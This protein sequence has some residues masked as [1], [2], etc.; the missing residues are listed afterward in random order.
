MDIT[1]SE[2]IINAIGIKK[3]IVFGI[4]EDELRWR[5][6]ETLSL[7]TLGEDKVLALKKLIEGVKDVYGSKAILFT[8]KTW[9]DAKKDMSSVIVHK[10]EH[11]DDLLFTFVRQ[12]PHKWLFQQHTKVANAMLAYYVEHIEYIPAQQ[13]RDYRR[14]AFVRVD[15]IYERYGKKRKED[16]VFYSSDVRGKRIRDILLK[17]NLVPETIDLLAVHKKEILRYSDLIPQIGKQFTVSGVATD[18]VPDKHTWGEHTFTFSD[19]RRKNRVVIDTFTD[20]ENSDDDDDREPYVSEYFW[21]NIRIPK[22]TD[23]EEDSAENEES[24]I[25]I[26]IPVQPFVIVFDLFRHLRLSVHVNYLN[27]YVYDDTLADKLILPQEVKYLISMLVEQKDGNF[28]DIVAGKGG[29]AIIL[30][31]G[32]PGVGKTLTAEVFAEADKKPLYSVQASQLG[33]NPD[34]LEKELM[35]VLNRASRWNAIMLLDEADVYVHERG[36]DLTQ[37]AIVGVFLRVLEYHSSVLFLTTNRPE[38][39][40]DAIASRCVARIDYQYPDK[41]NQKKIWKVLCEASNINID[42]KEYFKFAELNPN[43]SGRDVKNLLKLS[44]LI[45]KAKNEPITC[46]TLQYVLKFKPTVEKCNNK[47]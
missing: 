38:L 33:T 4:S 5:H 1:L 7:N 24:F 29:G 27:E 17:H 6:K 34:E 42:K 14:P 19:D 31:T 43:I 47:V 20:E 9:D 44:T 28:K 3:M 10:L 26:E 16:F 45:S 2:K 8:F 35:S 22:N 46:E 18:K 40:D 12:L 23:D 30:L 15:C 37:N 13:G 36:N 39:V 32:V 21:K 11:F 25:D 41:E